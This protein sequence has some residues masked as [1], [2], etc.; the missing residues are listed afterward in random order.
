MILPHR[1]GAPWRVPIY[2]RK[3]GP[4]HVKMSYYCCRYLASVCQHSRY[5]WVIKR[6]ETISVSRSQHKQMCG[7]HVLGIAWRLLVSAPGTFAYLAPRSRGAGRSISRGFGAARHDLQRSPTCLC[8]MSD[9]DIRCTSVP[10]RSHCSSRPV[11]HD[12]TK[13]IFCVM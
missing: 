5:P 6:M 4:N 1:L 10:L 3:N 12:R 9:L 13:Y 11:S 8:R 7:P 2:Y